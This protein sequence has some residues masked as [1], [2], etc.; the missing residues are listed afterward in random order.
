MEMDDPEGADAA[1]RRT[2]SSSRARTQGGHEAANGEGYQSGAPSPSLYRRY[3]LNR[4][5]SSVFEDVEMAQ[6]EVGSPSPHHFS[7]DSLTNVVT[8]SCT[9]ALWPSPSP[10]AYPPF[11]ADEVVQIRRP[12]LPSTRTRPKT[13]TERRCLWRKASYQS[14]TWTRFPSQLTSKKMRRQL[15][16]CFCQMAVHSTAVDLQKM[17]TLPW[18]AEG[19]R[20]ALNIRCIHDSY[21]ARAI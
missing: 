11:T 6:D 1:Q 8:R 12:V 9:L 20:H 7:R 4:S 3:S 2:S 10:P 18:R 15:R 19:L 21:D 14:R 5:T 16:V 17:M 13:L